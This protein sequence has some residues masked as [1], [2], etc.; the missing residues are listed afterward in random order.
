MIELKNNLNT[1]GYVLL[2][3]IIKE[4]DVNNIK[5]NISHTE[6][7]YYIAKNYIDTTII[8][9]V[10]TLFNWDC[11][12]TKYRVSNLSNSDASTFHRDI[13]SQNNINKSKR[14]LSM[15]MTIL[16]YLDT[17]SI[18]LIPKTHLLTNMK[19]DKAINMYKT[20]IEIKIEP[21]DILVFY[22]TII[23]RGLFSRKTENRRL[24]Q[25]FE[26]YESYDRYINIKNKIYHVPTTKDHDRHDNIMKY[27]SKD[28]YL[29]GIPNYLAYLN[30]ALG[31]GYIKNNLDIEYLSSDGFN[32]RLELSKQL[33]DQAIYPIDRYIYTDKPIDL[34]EEYIDDF[35]YKCYYRFYY[36]VIL[37]IVIAI[38]IIILLLDI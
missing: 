35:R 21:T 27:I 36:L 15:P 31:Y 30:A 26:V 23:H 24:I 33:L 1:F 12:Y 34:P 25:I 5:S 18:E 3:N 37:C 11:H 10:N 28:K 16:S 9:T 6:V 22:S 29:I 13:I 20:K 32:D 17:T 19:L 38:I 2:K 7:N 4:N 8:K 14:V